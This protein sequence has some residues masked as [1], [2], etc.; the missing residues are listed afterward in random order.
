MP[1]SLQLADIRIVG[2][3][4]KIYSKGYEVALKKKNINDAIRYLESMIEEIDFNI[5]CLQPLRNDMVEM[6]NRK[7]DIKNTISDHR[8]TI[9]QLKGELRR[10]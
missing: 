10:L 8:L 9:D 4:L 5:E 3:D 6:D 2:N 7:K 1:M